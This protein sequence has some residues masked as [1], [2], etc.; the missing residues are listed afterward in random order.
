MPPMT[1]DELI[2]SL[3]DL[4]TENPALGASEIVQEMRPMVYAPINPPVVHELALDEETM[5]YSVLLPNGHWRS[6]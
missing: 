1:V 4:C 6:T 2:L 3:V 5:A